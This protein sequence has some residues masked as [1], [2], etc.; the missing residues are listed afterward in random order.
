MHK[1]VK[2]AKV[3]HDPGQGKCKSI[4]VKPQCSSSKYGFSQTDTMAVNVCET[5]IAASGN[6]SN[7]A[8]LT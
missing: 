7:A 6:R 4:T 5:A 3:F 1:R 8:K 2:Y